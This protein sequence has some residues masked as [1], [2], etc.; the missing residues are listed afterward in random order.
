MLPDLSDLTVEQ[1]ITTEK[2]NEKVTQLLN[3]VATH[4]NAMVQYYAGGMQLH[5]DSD[6]SYLLV[7]EGQSRVGGYHYSSS[8]SAN[9]TKPPNTIPGMNGVILVVCNIMQNVMA[10]AAEAKM[11]VLLINGQEVAVLE[12]ILEEMG[13][14]QQPTPMK[15]DNSTAYGI[16]NSSIRQRQSQ[17]MDM[18]FYWVKNRVQ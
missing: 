5:A 3:Y 9:R 16:V 13:W 7:T 4:Q 11:G 17:A 14:P 12:Q 8:S 2:T 1:T 18:H 15:T 6:V 10:L